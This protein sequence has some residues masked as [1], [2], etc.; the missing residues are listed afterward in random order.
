[1][2]SDSK[3]RRITLL[4]APNLAQA[5]GPNWY[6]VALLKNQSPLSAVLFIQEIQEIQDRGMQEWDDLDNA[7]KKA[8]WLSP[9]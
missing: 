8:N 3:P 2:P 5:G 1:M 6:P 9:R 7:S 4:A